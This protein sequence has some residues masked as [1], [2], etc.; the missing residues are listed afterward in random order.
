MTA[1]PPNPVMGNNKAVAA[2]LSGAVCTIAVYII[3]QFLKTPLPAE[4]V[5][6]LQTIVTTGLVWFVPHGGDA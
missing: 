3:D 5:A 4:I 1:L 6:A 2:V